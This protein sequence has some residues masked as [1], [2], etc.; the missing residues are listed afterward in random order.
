MGYQTDLT[1]A[2]WAFIE[3]IISPQ[4]GSGRPQEVDL[5]RV[6]DALMYQDRTGCR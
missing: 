2:Q 1:D 6:L 5:R 3:P 4:E